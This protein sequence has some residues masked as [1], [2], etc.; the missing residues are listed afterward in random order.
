MD[1]EKMIKQQVTRQW[2]GYIL[3][4]LLTALFALAYELDLLAEGTWV[5]QVQKEY[6]GETVSV[7]LTMA[8]IPLALKLYPLLL[9]RCVKGSEEGR[10]RAYGH[11]FLIRLLLLT[12]SAWL[13]LWVYYATLNNIGGL[14]ALITM[15]ASLFCMPGVQKLKE[16]LLLVD[17]NK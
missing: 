11:L 12:V 10:L 1:I 17:A 5:G 6:V 9:P 2:A 4:W 14:C 8:L 7:L 13:N 3:F 16:D 15:T